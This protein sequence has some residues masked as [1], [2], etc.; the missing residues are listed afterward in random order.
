[1]SEMENAI[2]QEMPP[3]PPQM[4]SP[5][6]VGIVRGIEWLADGMRLFGANAAA[7]IGICVVGFV[8]MLALGILNV[9]PGAGLLIGIFTY[10]W[11]G[12]LMIGCRDAD[13]GAE[14]KLNH[15]FAGFQHRLDTLVLLGIINQI[16]S[17]LIMLAVVGPLYWDIL[18]GNE[19]TPNPQ[20]IIE[21]VVLPML[22]AFSLLLPLMMCT[23]FAP[24]LI[25]LQNKPVIEAMKLS[26]I[27]CARNVLPFLL[28]GVVQ[29]V[30]A[31]VA[32][33]PFF[34]GLLVF[35]PMLY[36]SIYAAYK[37]IFLHQPA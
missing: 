27:G 11:I 5:R 32:A 25:V 34:L 22:I 28:Y 8:M 36:G 1:M 24:A 18:M 33:L 21:D 29:L 15:L 20:T 16:L 6:N 19:W 7:W 4:H 12:G 14:L 37:D 30:A 3:L 2:Q 13:Q 35:I 17:V 9:I 23:W 31:I 10:V 26:F